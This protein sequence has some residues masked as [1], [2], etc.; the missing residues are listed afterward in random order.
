[1]KYWR[2]TYASQMKRCGA[3]PGDLKCPRDDH[4]GGWLKHT[5]NYIY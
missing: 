3:K 2:C 4:T 1:M 5:A